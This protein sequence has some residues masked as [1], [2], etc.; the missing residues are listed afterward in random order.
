MAPRAGG[1]LVLGGALAWRPVAGAVGYVVEVLTSEGEV[2]FRAT[3]ADTTVAFTGP[4]AAKLEPGMAVWM[5]A[6]HLSG[7]DERRSVPRRVVIG[8]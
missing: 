8:R 6:A 5:V 4:D 1:T 7:G 2:A 3:T